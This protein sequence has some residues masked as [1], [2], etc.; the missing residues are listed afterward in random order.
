MVLVAQASV[1]AI[2]RFG[3]SVMASWR[4]HTSRSFHK[5][6]VSLTQTLTLLYGAH[7]RAPLRLDPCLEYGKVFVNRRP[8]SLIDP[9]PLKR[10]RW[11]VVLREQ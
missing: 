4:H 5:Y 10:S 6:L 1:P 8:N 7:G 11:Q 9:Y 2:V 3:L